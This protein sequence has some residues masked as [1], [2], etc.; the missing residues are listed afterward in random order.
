MITYDGSK[1]YII[2]FQLLPRH[3]SVF[4]HILPQL[5][6][7]AALAVLAPLILSK[8]DDEYDAW[9]NNGHKLLSAPLAFLLVFRST[10]SF[11]RYWEG[12]GHLGKIAKAI[13]DLGRQSCYY[14]N[15]KDEGGARATKELLRYSKLFYNTLVMHLREETDLQNPSMMDPSLMTDLERTALEESPRRPLVVLGW[16][17]C[18]LSKL[19][20]RNLLEEEEL[21]HLD[22]TITEM[23][24]GFNGC[25]KIKKTPMPFPYVQMVYIFA[26]LYLGLLPFVMVD[27]FGMLTVF[28]ATLM[29]FSMFGINQV[30]VEIEDPFGYDANDLPMEK[31]GAALADDVDGYASR[32]AEEPFSGDALFDE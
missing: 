19:R 18:A 8:G 15:A 28:P 32:A 1:W 17:T 16:M 7:I 25:D 10:I 22:S 23:I 9:P 14:I 3:G 5:G 24:E 11:G 29:A 31:T 27:L 20:K 13:R 21:I 2:F 4:P 12:R 6:L 30:G 26:F